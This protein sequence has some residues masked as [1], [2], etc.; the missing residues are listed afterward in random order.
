M[1]DKSLYQLASDSENDLE[2]WINA[3]NKIIQQGNEDKQSISSTDE[4]EQDD[5]PLLSPSKPETLRESLE[6]SKH[7]ELMKY[8]KETERLNAIR[9]KDGRQKLFGIYPTLQTVGRMLAEEKLP[10]VTP[11]KEHFGTRVMVVCEELKFRL[12]AVINEHGEIVDSQ[13]ENTVNGLFSVTAPHS[14]IY[15]VARI[16]K[17]LQGNITTCVEPYMKSGD[18][19]KLSQK[20]LKQAK[21]FCHRMGD[22]RMPFAWAARP[23]FQDKQVDPHA[24]FTPFYKQESARL[25][26]DDLLKHLKDIKA[27][28]DKLGKLQVV[29]G[30]LKISVNPVKAL[31][32]NCLTPSL[33][34]L[35]PY[36]IPPITDVL[37]EI[38]EFIP[39]E[40][41]FSYPHTNYVNHLYVYPRSLKYDGQKAFNKVFILKCLL[42]QHKYIGIK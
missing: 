37:L 41:R 22:Y 9:R 13:E 29:P 3:F 30:S 28:P 35:D 17:V 11:F 25:S 6:Q 34:P 32:P 24:D 14:E 27:S 4:L 40:G 19:L 1:Q 39:E 31:P 16:E 33:V 2:D 5:D 18:I 21:I 8:A 23:L 10:T 42:F 12:S 26:D 7:P 20:L 38:E 36:P 15:L